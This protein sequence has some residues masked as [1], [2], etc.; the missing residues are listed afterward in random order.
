MS[1]VYIV[2]QCSIQCIDFQIKFAKHNNFHAFFSDSSKWE[3]FCFIRDISNNFTMS[4]IG[5]SQRKKKLIFSFRFLTH[6]NC[7]ISKILTNI[8]KQIAETENST[9]N[10]IHFIHFCWMFKSQMNISLVL[11]DNLPEVA[12]SLLSNGYFF[13]TALS[14][15]R[16]QKMVSNLDYDIQHIVNRAFV[17]VFIM[18]SF[19]KNNILLLIYREHSKCHLFWKLHHLELAKTENKW[20]WALKQKNIFSVNDKLEFSTRLKSNVIHPKW[21]NPR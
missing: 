6:C 13:T 20:N 9:S 11:Y 1:S 16:R 10:V 5:R 3:A 14:E 4:I 18:F 7:N 21:L 2:Y 19:C 15:N 8:R 17:R 12:F